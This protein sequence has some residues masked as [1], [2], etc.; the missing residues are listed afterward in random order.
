MF[1]NTRDCAIILWV[2]SQG[3][4]W[5]F[6]GSYGMFEAQSDAGYYHYT[7]HIGLWSD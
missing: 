1:S 2:I 4:S 5:F 7:D 6:P 3:L